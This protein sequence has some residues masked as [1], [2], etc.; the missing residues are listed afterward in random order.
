MSRRGLN[1][2]KEIAMLNC[3]KYSGEPIFLDQEDMTDE[4]WVFLCRIFG[5]EGKDP[6]EYIR[7]TIE[8]FEACVKSTK[9]EPDSEHSSF[10]Y[11]P[12]CGAS[13][14]KIKNSCSHCGI[15]LITNPYFPEG[16]AY[17][18]KEAVE[19]TER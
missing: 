19:D 16:G 2:R 17:I 3:Y 9:E 15:V 14:S 7:F 13:I 10:R 8:S 11:C 6:S 1:G 18:S 5:F 4:E 12:N